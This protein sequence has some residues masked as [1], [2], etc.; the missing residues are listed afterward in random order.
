MIRSG[1]PTEMWSKK[2]PRILPQKMPNFGTENFLSG[3]QKVSKRKPTVTNKVSKD[4]SVQELLSSGQKSH[5]VARFRG[6][7]LSKPAKKQK[8]FDFFNFFQLF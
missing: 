3:G 1:L 7:K 6:Q 2:S 4:P 8:N 5:L